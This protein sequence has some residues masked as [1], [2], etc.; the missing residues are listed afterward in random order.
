MDPTT[1]NPYPNPNQDDEQERLQN[2]HNPLAVMQPGEHMVCELRRHPIG[3]IG[4]YISAAL[5]IILALAGA[6]AVPYFLPDASQQVKLGTVL[7]AVI[8]AAMTL[9]YAYIVSIVYNGNRW[10]VT[11]D[12][13]TQID[14]NGLLSRQTS[15]LSLANLEDVTIEQ[16]GLL[17]SIFDFG[18]L[19]AETAGQRGKFVFPFC[20][21]PTENAR[22]IIA[23][24]EAYIAHNPEETYT[25]NRSV[26][27]THSLNQPGGPIQNM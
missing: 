11:S 12:S 10:I 9:L 7:G 5:I 22:K 27:N 21:N 8:L 26:A 4:I 23:A 24:H 1:P 6:G 18:S 2:I 3:L 17:Q 16:D 19:R 13:I 15:Q 14:Q 20:P 25:A